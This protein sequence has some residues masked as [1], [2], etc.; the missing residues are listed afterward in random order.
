M[1]DTIGAEGMGLYQLIMPLYMLVWSLTS[2]GFSTAIS[3][4]T[5]AENAAKKDP[6]PI[7]RCA[8]LLSVSLSIVIGVVIHKKADFI[9]IH[10]LNDER[11]ALSLHLIS[12][13]F[14]FMALGSCVRGYFFGMQNS[15]P[16]AVSQ[17]AE[18]ITRM[19][20]IFAIGSL[21]IP[22][23]IEYACAAAVTG[24]CVGEIVSCIYVV[25]CY[26]TRRK[27]T[28]R[29]KG[30][31]KKAACKS[32]LWVAVPLTLNRL[33][34]SL[35]STF[36][37]ILIPSRL[38]LYGLTKTE[39]VS[40]F[41][42]L[43]GMAM[44][45]LMFPSSF[46]TAVSITIVPAISETCERH[47][48]KTLKTTIEKSILFAAI[49]GFAASA[50]FIS[51]PGEISSLIY[52]DASIGNILFMLG[53]ISPFMY[54]NVILAGILNG[55]GEQN[56]IFINGLTGSVICLSFVW[57]AVPR[58]GIYGCILGNLVS[59]TVVSSLNIHKVSKNVDLGLN[60][61]DIFIKPL[62]ISMFCIFA[63]RL[64]KPMIHLPKNI[65]TI[66]CAAA[67]SAMFAL[68]LLITGTVSTADLK[69]IS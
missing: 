13:C 47:N 22:G 32:I 7:L 61:A 64:I 44:P 6:R 15:L 5:A 25:I 2:S 31:S 21:L 8:A 68:L 30:L 20:V 43:T 69:R 48:V 29:L 27:P 51:L 33:A 58:L 40:E 3:K 17:V 41:G 53:F 28:A 36:E 52:G 54:V 19:A 45:L 66:L 55:L 23:G 46:L 14:P 60:A 39:A 59:M 10:L 65:S 56:A 26:I 62:L 57:F 12:F 38:M 49:T 37:N 18:Q 24:M 50:L 63:V 34:S 11:C 1:A 35:L 67:M 4:L 16:P 42:R 9:A